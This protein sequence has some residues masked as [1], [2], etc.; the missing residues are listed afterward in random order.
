MKSARYI[1]VP[2]SQSFQ[3]VEPVIQGSTYR[4]RKMKCTWFGAKLPTNH[5]I[6]CARRAKPVRPEP[7]GFGSK[8]IASCIRLYTVYTKPQMHWILPGTAFDSVGD[9]TW[10]G[11]WSHRYSRRASVK[12]MLRLNTKSVYTDELFLKLIL[13]LTSWFPLDRR[14]NE[15]T[16]TFTFHAETFTVWLFVCGHRCQTHFRILFFSY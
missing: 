15:T 3:H 13:H 11:P 14:G 6:H 7:S 12:W 16:F 10:R 9:V 1:V 8:Y 4:R 2:T 5:G